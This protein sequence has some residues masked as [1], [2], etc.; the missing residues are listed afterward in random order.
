MHEYESII[1]VHVMYNYKSLLYFKNLEISIG[2]QTCKG[3]LN[4]KYFPM[5]IPAYKETLKTL[6]FSPI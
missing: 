6:K 4:K 3:R 5:E 2:I 1:Q